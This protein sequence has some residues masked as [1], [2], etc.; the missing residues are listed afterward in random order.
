MTTTAFATTL[1]M[2]ERVQGSLLP[3]PFPGS[4][5][6]SA[7]AAFRSIAGSSRPMNL[8]RCA[9]QAWINLAHPAASLVYL[10]ST[11]ALFRTAPFLWPQRMRSRPCKH[12]AS[13]M[14]GLPLSPRPLFL[15]ILP[16]KDST[17][18]MSSCLSVKDV[19]VDTCILRVCTHTCY[20]YIYIYICHMYYILQTG[21]VHSATSR[22][23]FGP[24]SS[25]PAPGS[26]S[27]F[28]QTPPTD[29]LAIWKV[30][31]VGLGGT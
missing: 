29:C 8:C 25:T 7:A 20:I 22:M 15:R 24:A 23:V 17:R 18:D 2:S 5:R 1:A 11:T 6:P 26:G 3:W 9:T 12:R 19:R 31:T 13:S 30:T 10:R 14:A 21:P 16:S 28:L 4:A 27:S